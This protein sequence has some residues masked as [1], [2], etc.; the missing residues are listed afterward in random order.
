MKRENIR[1]MR[2]SNQTQFPRTP[3]ISMPASAI[4]KI[5]SICLARNRLELEAVVEIV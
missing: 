2:C 4:K 5:S 3:E 1:G